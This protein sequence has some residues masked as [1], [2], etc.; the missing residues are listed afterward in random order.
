MSG[1]TPGSQMVSATPMCAETRDKIPLSPRGLGGFA[2][3]TLGERGDCREG[4][5]A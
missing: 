2:P 1:K 3:P 5:A 4:I